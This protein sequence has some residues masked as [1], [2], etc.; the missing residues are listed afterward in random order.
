MFDRIEMGRT[1]REYVPYEK[2]VQEHKAPTDDSV[3]LY[4]EM[5]R[6]CR[7]ELVRTLKSEGNEMRWA[8]A[9][10]ADILTLGWVVQA[11]V[12]VN[13]APLRFSWNVGV[14]AGDREIM[15]GLYQ[16]LAN[17][18]AKQMIHDLLPKMRP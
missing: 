9:V 3:R 4:G 10:F 14:D 17:R 18:L 8:L 13:G 2:T 11:E 15:M 5:H 1:S 6:R 16:E 7:E 12:R